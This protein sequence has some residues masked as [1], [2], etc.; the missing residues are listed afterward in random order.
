MSL[1]LITTIY[2]NNFF[3]CETAKGSRQRWKKLAELTSLDETQ[4]R[5]VMANRL[6]FTQLLSTVYEN[7]DNRGNP[8]RT[9][10]S[11]GEKR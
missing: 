8:M 2:R 3:F 11:S 10:V 7:K 6:E 9:S 5:R 4:L 1:V